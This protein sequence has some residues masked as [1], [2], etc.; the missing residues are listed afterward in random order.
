MNEKNEQCL[1]HTALR[2]A[3][4][5]TEQIPGNDVL[6]LLHEVIPYRFRRA[7]CELRLDELLRNALFIGRLAELANRLYRVQLGI[8]RNGKEYKELD[9]IC[10][11]V[12]WKLLRIKHS[13]LQNSGRYVLPVLRP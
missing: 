6:V 5:E 10:L 7:P 2:G 9:A 13:P 11:L 1:A 8:T 4:H 3:A 12:P